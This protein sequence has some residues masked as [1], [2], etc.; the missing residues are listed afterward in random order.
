MWS[1]GGKHLNALGLRSWILWCAHLNRRCLV[2]CLGEV[3]KME[4]IEAIHARCR[5]QMMDAFN[6]DT[7]R[8]SG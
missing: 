6:L 8:C 5:Y 1:V 3:E 4:L 2:A 7:T